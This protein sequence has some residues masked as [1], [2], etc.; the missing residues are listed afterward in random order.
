M[1]KLSD[2]RDL[3]EKEMRVRFRETLEYLMG[4]NNKVLAFEADLGAASSFSKIQDSYPDNYVQMGIS[5]AN[6]VGVAASTSMRGFIPY[7]HTFS[8]FASRRVADQVYL[9]GAYAHNTLNIF[10]SDPG[11]CAATNGGTHT[12]FEDIA[13]YR[14]IPGAMVFDP[15]DNVQLDWLIKEVA[16]L[17]GVHYIRASRKAVSKIYK[18]GSK[19]E[20]GKGN[21]IR[22]GTNVLLITM[23]ILINDALD[24]AIELEK[25]GISVEVVDMFTIKPL[26]SELIKTQLDGKKLVVTFENHNIINGL[27]SAVAEIMAETGSKIKLKRIGVEDRFGQVGSF[28][29]LK[30]EYGLTKEHVKSAI[31]DLVK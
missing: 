25:E 30:K 22:K 12:T 1:W 9:T 24:A 15:A 16:T 4:E 17:K 2:D 6:M 18:E 23:G 5:E 21:V 11:V 13:L 7:I 31:L 3:E 19:F 28:E 29:F 20:I 14:A 8:P 27:G 26:D 10:G